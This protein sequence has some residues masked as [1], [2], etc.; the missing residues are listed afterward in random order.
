M[1]GGRDRRRGGGKGAEGK[2]KQLSTANKR[3]TMSLTK[4]R[5]NL[6]QGQTIFPWRERSVL[7]HG[8]QPMCEQG[9]MHGIFSVSTLS[10]QYMQAAPVSDMAAISS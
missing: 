2:D 6:Q 5:A 10:R 9:S 7:R 1:G 4:C 8:M 3:V